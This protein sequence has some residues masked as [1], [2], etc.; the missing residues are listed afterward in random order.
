[1]KNSAAKRVPVKKLDQEVFRL[2]GVSMGL[3]RTW[4]AM[5][6]A[7]GAF[8]FV[9]ESAQATTYVRGFVRPSGDG[10]N[11]CSVGGNCVQL[12][13][14]NPISIDVNGVA[15]TL[16]FDLIGFSTD[17][18]RLQTDPLN[19]LDALQLDP[20]NIQAGNTLTFVFSGPAPNVN[21]A[22]FGV[23]GC[24]GLAPGTNT[25]AILD[26][27]S[28]NVVSTKCTNFD[29]TLITDFSNPSLDSITFNLAS[30]INFPSQF[31]FSF[32]DGALPTQ[33]DI[34]VPTGGGGNGGGTATP[35]PAS[36]TLLAAG[37]VG[38]G[39]LR[40]RRAA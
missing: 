33:I 36:V 19:F 11:D 24:G 16:S 38:L 13:S 1:L 39:A 9:A 32:P 40:R 28:V 37:L 3:K 35:E 34:T 20:L 29:G 10:P 27:S 14:T 6:I 2:R 8:V 5:L 22:D 26:S 31:A 30:G 21:N 17:S 7:V 25:G 23:L 12:F 18:S 15:Q 4:F